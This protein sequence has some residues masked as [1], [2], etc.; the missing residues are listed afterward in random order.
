MAE[1]NRNCS[2]S[3]GRHFL[4]PV[5]LVRMD[6]F[7]RRILQLSER[8]AIKHD[9]SVDWT[10]FASHVVQCEQ[11]SDE[12]THLQHVSGEETKAISAWVTTDCVIPSLSSCCGAVL[13]D[14]D[15]TSVPAAS[16]YEAGSGPHRYAWNT[17]Q[18]VI[19]ALCFPT[20]CWEHLKYCRK[21]MPHKVSP[22]F[23]SFAIQ[24]QNE[25]GGEEK[26]DEEAC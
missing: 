3:F 20:I 25:R 18:D 10:Q 26:C 16:L 6:E 21:T 23:C 12:P 2:I 17:N 8:K 14:V 4:G 15:G 19:S 11:G 5:I 7:G 24:K 1:W 22:I 9:G 13:K